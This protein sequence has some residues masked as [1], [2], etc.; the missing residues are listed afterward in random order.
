MPFDRMALF[1]DRVGVMDL[2]E[3]GRAAMRRLADGRN[4]SRKSAQERVGLE[5]LAKVGLAEAMH[6]LDGF[7]SAFHH[8]ELQTAI[9]AGLVVVDRPSGMTPDGL[10][11]QML[12]TEGMDFDTYIEQL[13]K[14]VGS[15]SSHTL[16]DIKLGDVVG[17]LAKVAESLGLAI[18]PGMRTRSAAV[19]AGAE[20]MGRLPAFPTATIDEVLDIRETLASSLASFRASMMEATERLDVFSPTFDNDINDLW[21]RKVAPAIEAIENNVREERIQNWLQ[22]GVGAGVVVAASTIAEKFVDGSLSTRSLVAT[23]GVAAAEKYRR[24]R[25]LM[26]ELRKQPFWYLYEI[27]RQL[28]ES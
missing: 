22:P 11:R 5:R 23:V 12:G 20:L 10:F 19:S 9:E 13:A 2:G 25:K 24:D 1:L 14:T 27:D 3:E 26:S 28:G 6:E 4:L 17:P 18:D 16:I 8:D 7:L 21:L 15:E